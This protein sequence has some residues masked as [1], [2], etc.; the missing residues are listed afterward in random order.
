MRPALIRVD[1]DRDYDAY[2]DI[3]DWKGTVIYSLKEVKGLL[4]S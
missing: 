2:R 1:Y 4:A 3:T